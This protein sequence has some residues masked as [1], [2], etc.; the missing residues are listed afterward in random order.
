MASI[1][2]AACGDDHEQIGF[3]G[4]CRQRWADQQAEIVICH[5]PLRD[6]DNPARAVQFMR[7]R[8]ERGLVGND[9]K[10][11]DEMHRGWDVAWKLETRNRQLHI[12]ICKFYDGV[13]NSH[14]QRPNA[15]VL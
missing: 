4:K 3:V 2:R 10:G 12:G 13:E 5:R 6:K 7:P 8:R 9:G 15:Q 11:A 1:G 14:R